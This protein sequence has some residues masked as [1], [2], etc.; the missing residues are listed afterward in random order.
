[1]SWRG[2]AVVDP[3]EGVAPGGRHQRLD[4]QQHEVL[5]ADLPE[6]IRHAARDHHALHGAELV[7]DAVLAHDRHAALQHQPEPVH[8]RMQVHADLAPFGQ[9]LDQ[10]ADDVGGGKAHQRAVG[11]GRDRRLLETEQ[12]ELALVPGHQLGL[13]A[14]QQQLAQCVGRIERH[15]PG[16]RHAAAILVGPTGQLGALAGCCLQLGIVKER[17]VQIH[18]GVELGARRRARRLEGLERIL[19]GRLHHRLGL[20][21]DQ[22]IVAH[23]LEGIGHAARHHDAVERPERMLHAVFTNEGCR[24]LEHHPQTVHGGMQVQGLGFADVEHLDVDAEDV[25]GGEA[26]HGAHL[27]RPEL[28]LAKMKGLKLP[29]MRRQEIRLEG[30][31]QKAPERGVVVESQ[32]FHGALRV[33]GACTVPVC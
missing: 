28:G 4:L 10:R 3:L 18:G 8:G 7:L 21:N 33:S 9:H 24:T 25:G 6:G 29:L 22:R 30:A 2:V 16:L 23:L 14:A 26:H 27:A 12:L 32:G 20:Q 17:I 11:A 1:M 19:P 15:A 31:Q 5:R 13:D